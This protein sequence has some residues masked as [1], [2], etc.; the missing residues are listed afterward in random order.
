[1]DTRHPRLEVV[2]Q[3]RLG[4]V[5]QRAR[6]AVEGNGCRIFQLACDVLDT[7]ERGR[8]AARTPASRRTPRSASSFRAPLE[9][10]QVSGRRRPTRT[11]SSAEPALLE[12]RASAARPE[13]P[14]GFDSTPGCPSSCLKASAALAISGSM[15]SALLIPVSSGRSTR[16]LTTPCAAG[17][18]R[19]GRASRWLFAGRKQPHD[20]I[21]LV[22]Q[23]HRRP[24]DRRL[25][26]LRAR[27]RRVGLDADRQVVEVD[28]LP[29]FFGQPFLA[30]VDAAHGALE[31]GELADHVGRQVRLGQPR[32]L[33]GVTQRSA[34][35][36]QAPRAAIH[37]ASRAI[38]SAF[39]GRC[40]S[41]L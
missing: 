24:G 13:A 35:R 27:R 14:S 17:A 31:L 33:L 41:F 3:L 7:L 8:P 20:R 37:R 26:E 39:S 25:A 29:D 32:R 12:R 1:M 22:G 4:R 6:E 15:D 11:Y 40:P 10:R 19:T 9:R 34:R 28:R 2:E 30:R 21:Q 38:R 16:I 36:R 23:R 18:G 5:A